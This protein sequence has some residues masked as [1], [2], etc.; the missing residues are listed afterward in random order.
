MKN[1]VILGL[2]GLQL[3]FATMLMPFMITSIELYFFIPG[4]GDFDKMPVTGVS[5]RLK[6][7]VLIK[8]LFSLV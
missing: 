2:V 6:V 4:F 1:Y 8:F 7:Q 5:G 3:S